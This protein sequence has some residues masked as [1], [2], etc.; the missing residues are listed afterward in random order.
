MTGPITCIISVECGLQG[1]ARRV[2]GGATAEACV[3]S[4]KFTLPP[5]TL[6]PEVFEQLATLLLLISNQEEQQASTK[7]PKV[8][9]LSKAYMS[10]QESVRPL[11]KKEAR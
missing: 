10:T 5:Q 7:A 9:G 2:S 11:S 8:Q 6:S 4:A 1:R 3:L